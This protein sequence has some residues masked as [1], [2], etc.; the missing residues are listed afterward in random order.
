MTI[1]LAWLLKRP[2]LLVSGALAL[3]LCVALAQVSIT[4]SQRD[5]ARAEA[6][7][8]R[9]EIEKQNEAI[10]A[11]RVAADIQQRLAEDAGQRAAQVRTV[12]QTRVQRVLAA[13]VPPECPAAMRWGA[14]RAAEITARWRDE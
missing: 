11:W 10:S 6:V 2:W 3:G 7:Q 1:V 4:A 8:S 13:P 9:A 14:E 12:T 5:A